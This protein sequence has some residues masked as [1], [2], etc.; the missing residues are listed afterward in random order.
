[1][2]Q[3]FDALESRASQQG[4]APLSAFGF[5]DDILGQVVV[6]HPA[7]S[8]L[9]TV[10]ALVASS[11]GAALVNPK[12]L[13]DLQATEAALERAEAA[14]VRFAVV[15]RIGADDWISPHEMDCRK[16]SFW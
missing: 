3:G 15:V 1:M 4:V 7:D 8:G 13:E 9:K 2:A 5:G 16:G 14:A 12:L 11:H 10:R 6:W